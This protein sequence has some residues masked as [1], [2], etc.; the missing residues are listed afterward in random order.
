MSI[1]LKELPKQ[2]KHTLY[3]LCEF[4]G[5]IKGII[6]NNKEAK[7][8]LQNFDKIWALQGPGMPNRP[9]FSDPGLE[10]M[11]KEIGG[12][13]RKFLTLNI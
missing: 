13:C 6:I 1:D 9:I 7:T 3:C 11:N 8:V 10:F 2:Y 12:Y 4:S 5:F